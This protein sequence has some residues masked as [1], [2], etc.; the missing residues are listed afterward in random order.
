VAR[1]HKPE[2]DEGMIEE[3]ESLADRMAGWI[4]ANVRLVVAVVVAS[5]V[6]AAGYGAYDTWHGRREARA[7]DA[8][9][10]V[11][12]DYLQA[13]GAG[14]SAFEI[15]ELANPDAARRINE[16]YA[17]RFREV[18]EEHPGTIAGALAALELGNVLEAAGDPQ[19]PIDTWNAAI[20]SLPRNSGLRGVLLQRVA[21]AHE[22][23]ER[24]PDAAATHERAGNLEAFPLRWWALADAA[25]CYVRADDP[26]RARE[27]FDRIESQQPNLRLPAHIRSLMREVRASGPAGSTG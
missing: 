24:W 5:L 7:A 6:A 20:E 18:A 11:R 8:L 10:R 27:L 25:R 22:D 13:M 14:P 15:P 16:E 17:V 1:K 2:H 19:G 12:I 4:G 21:T 23:A 9:D 26:D 3:I